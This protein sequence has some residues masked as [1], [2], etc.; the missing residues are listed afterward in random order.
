M[1]KYLKYYLFTLLI[2]SCTAC[3]NRPN[4]INWKVSLD[5]KSKHPY[6]AYLAHESVRYIFPSATIIDVSRDFRYTSIDDDM[7]HDGKGPSLLIASGL[8][9]Y[10]SQKEVDQL[11]YF[12]EAGN[13]VCI[14]S[15]ELD[16]KLE[17]TFHCKLWS[18]GDV[19]VP[20]TAFNTGVENMN[21][22]TIKGSTDSFGYRG[23]SL[24]AYF[25]KDTGT[26]QNVKLKSDSENNLHIGNPDTLGFFKGQTDFIR[27]NVG[28]GHI[29][30]HAAPLVLSNYFLLQPGNKKYLEAMWNVF[31]ENI[32]T[33]YWNDYYK[34]N[35][36]AS[37]LGVLL[38]YP[39]MKWAFLLAIATMLVYVIAES[40]RR[41][42]IIPEIKPL[43]N[44][45]VSFVETVG[46][47]Y[48]H[49][50]N[51][52]NLA[53]KMI[54]H[55]LEWVRT[56]YFINTNK[57]DEHFVHQL[58]IK[59]GISETTVQSLIQQIKEITLERKAINQEELYHLYHTIQQFYKND[60][61]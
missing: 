50:S 29:T 14:F 51:H 20:L 22:L 16:E 10:L 33:V 26:T 1:S 28:K 48:Y 43:D 27:Y 30:L 42:R 37:D 41:Q 59:S 21:A 39:S 53:E 56:H 58:T 17:R 54:Q 5:K 4:A 38:K 25:I 36:R 32:A 44:T 60:K 31:P 49:Q 19:E 12:A 15:S 3:I 9:F 46:R 55:F 40:R 23:K 2:T 24:V 61:R 34:R 47:L 52:T 13:E 57:F 7:I 45:S 18:K 11:L 8:Q 6:G 35:T